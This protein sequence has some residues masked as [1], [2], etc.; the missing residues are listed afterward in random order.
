MQTRLHK[1]KDTHLALA[2]QMWGSAEHASYVLLWKTQSHLGEDIM[3][4]LGFIGTQVSKELAQEIC[5]IA[6]SPYFFNLC[7]GVRP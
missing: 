7:F 6:S 3:A 5:E 1:K 2:P 4:A